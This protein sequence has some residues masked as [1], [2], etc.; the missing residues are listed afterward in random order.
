MRC[1]QACVSQATSCGHTIEMATYPT[2]ALVLVA[3]SG[4]LPDFLSQMAQLALLLVLTGQR[5]C[6]FEVATEIMLTAVQGVSRMRLHWWFGVQAV[7]TGQSWVAVW[8]WWVPASSDGRSWPLA[9]AGVG[10]YFAF[11]PPNNL[12][13]QERLK[14]LKGM[15]NL[16]LKALCRH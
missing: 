15:L 2:G 3:W 6:C 16:L 14:K 7:G 11:S 13:T 8:L 10:N 1:V 9:I 4:L 5:L 12:S